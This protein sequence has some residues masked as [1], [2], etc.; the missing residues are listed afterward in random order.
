M[1]IHRIH[2][3]SAFLLVAPVLGCDDDPAG[4]SGA[5][6]STDDPSSTGEPAESSGDDSPLE[7]VGDWVDDYGGQHQITNTAWIY[8]TGEFGVVTTN[9]MRHDNEAQWVAGEDAGMPGTFVRF[10]WAYDDEGTLYY[11]NTVYDATSLDA[12]IEAP[13]ADATDPA[14]TGCGGMFPWTMLTPA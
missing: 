13:L 1:Y 8:D 3:L 2:L 9:L 14:S 5:E 4:D 10:D 6:A 7:I 11:C 12:A